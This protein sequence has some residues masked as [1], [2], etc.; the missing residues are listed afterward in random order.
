MQAA[1]NFTP[2][3]RPGQDTTQDKQQ[4]V[5]AKIEYYSQ[6]VKDL[7]AKLKHAQILLK[8][9]QTWLEEITKGGEQ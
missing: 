9:H 7:E 3:A 6:Q 8:G 4:F 5:T 2:Q 1:Q